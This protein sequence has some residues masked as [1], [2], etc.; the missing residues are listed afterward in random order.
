MKSLNR[1]LNY[2][3][4]FELS[5]LVEGSAKYSF[6]GQGATWYFSSQANL[7]KFKADPSKYVPQYGGYCVWAMSNDK[8]A[9][10]KPPFWTIYKERY[11]SIT[12]K[13]F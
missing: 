13:I 9:P 7:E 12:I 8:A 5:K 1:Y 10:G 2:I 6:E 11:T 3:A 4:Y